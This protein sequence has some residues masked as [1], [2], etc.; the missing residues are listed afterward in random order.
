MKHM[1]I[2]PRE[3]RLLNFYRASELHGGL[4]LGGLVRR[5]SEPELILKLTRHSAEEVRHA[6]LWTEAI[7]D[8][9]GAPSPTPDTYQTRY[10]AVL[11]GRLSTVD[12]LALTQVFERRVYRHFLEHERRPGTHPRV[13]ECLRTMIEEERDHLSWVWEWLN[14]HAG[15]SGD[16]LQRIMRRFQEVDDQI[17]AALREEY[18]AWSVAA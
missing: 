15:L 16:E 4:V 14:E 5:A 9:G 6:E 1:E 12:V 3:L 8:V 18:Y 17:Y 11:E 13:R 10:A 2:T 7:L